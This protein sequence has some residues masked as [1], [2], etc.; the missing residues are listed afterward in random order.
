[1]SGA[2][3]RDLLRLT[4]TPGLGP[5]LIAR[6]LETFGSA[7]RVLGA[8]ARELE[9]VRG[10]GPAK[11]V[12]FVRGMKES[13]ALVEEE[14]ALVEQRGARL[15][16]KGEPGYPALLAG[17]PDAPPILYVRGTLDDAAD[18]YPVAIVG[19]RDCT[20]Y[21][22]EQAEKFAATLAGAGLTVVSGGARGIDAAA[23]RGALRAGG[24]TIVAVGCGLADCYPPEHAELYDRI[25]SGAQGGGGAI[26]SELPMRTPPDADNFPARNRIISGLS[27][28]VVVIE[29]AKGSGALITARLAAEDHGREVMVVPGRVDS[30]ASAGSLELL[31]K[32]GAAIV[33]EPAD[34]LQIL[35]TPAR[36]AFTGSHESRYADPARAPLFDPGLAEPGT[37]LPLS[38]VQRRIVDALVEPVTL[39]E[40]VASTALEPSVIRAEVT[41]LE[42]QGRVRRQGSRFGLGPT[43]R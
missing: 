40:L 3:L 35:E 14:M 18:R 10:V 2:A 23:H 39:D 30:P 5:V 20:A 41:L 36:H 25:A 28:G 38:E 26:V 34:V 29:A 31:K 19:S 15:V 1:M 13:A 12:A 42:L 17:A 32:G 24:R 21:G 33:T 6:L 16:V 22:I 8:S 9:R 43:G 7:A 4:L 37:G 11:S 27:L